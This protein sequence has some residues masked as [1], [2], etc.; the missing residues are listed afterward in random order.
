MV[1]FDQI[2]SHCNDI[3]TVNSIFNTYA[4]VRKKQTKVLSRVSVARPLY[5]KKETTVQ[6]YVIF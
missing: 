5:K 4:H 2:L 3:Y 1:V 6:T